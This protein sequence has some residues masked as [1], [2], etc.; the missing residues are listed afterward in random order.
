MCLVDSAQQL[1]QSALIKRSTSATGW[2]CP[3]LV[4]VDWA[5]AS[6]GVLA[7]RATVSRLIPKPP[8]GVLAIVGGAVP[9]IVTQ[10][11][12]H[13]NQGGEVN[14]HTLV[15][16]KDGEVVFEGRQRVRIAR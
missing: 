11:G 14:G 1:S 3:S 7:I 12:E 15:S 6:S 8:V 13:V 10:T 2:G 16:V 4:Q 5:C 9:Y